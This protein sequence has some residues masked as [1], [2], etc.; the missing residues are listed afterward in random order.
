[1]IAV[2]HGDVAG[3]DICDHLWN[4]ERV[5][6]RAVFFVER[7]ISG[8]FLKCV[9]TTDTGCYDYADAVAVNAFGLLKTAVL[10]SLTGCDKCILCIQVEL[11]ELA[12]VGNQLGSVEVFNLAGKLCL[13]KRGVEMCDRS[14]TAFAGFSGFPCCGNIVAKWGDGTKACH[15]YSF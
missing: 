14:C 1:M 9:K 2:F 15:Y 4:K 10:N 8:F 13:E 11:T 7:I 5:V 6:F 3:G 12:T